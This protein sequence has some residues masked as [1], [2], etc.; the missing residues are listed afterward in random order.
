M[1]ARH[2]AWLQFS[3]QKGAAVYTVSKET[4]TI[5]FLRPGRKNFRGS[6]KSQKDRARLP[7]EWLPRNSL[8]LCAQNE[9]KWEISATPSV[10]QHPTGKRRR[11]P[12][13]IT[14]LSSSP[15]R[16]EEVLDFRRL[17]SRTYRKIKIPASRTQY[18]ERAVRSMVD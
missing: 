6:R 18:R 12:Q 16:E 15:R 4:S 7:P 8:R 10:T 11:T 2:L 5:C 14:Q 1:E 9:R 3:R 17:F 13:P